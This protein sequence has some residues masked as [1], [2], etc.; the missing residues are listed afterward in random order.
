MLQSPPCASEPDNLTTNRQSGH[1]R[2][3]EALRLRIR[4][5]DWAPGSAIP[6][7]RHLAAE[8]KISPATVERA[9]VPLLTDGTL[10][11]DDRRGT[12]VSETVAIGQPATA[13]TS[14]S[15]PHLPASRPAAILPGHHHGPIALLA[16][17]YSPESR[18]AGQND[19]WVHEIVG[20]MEHDLAEHGRHTAFINRVPR[21]TLKPVSLGE[22]LEQALADETLSGLVIVAFDLPAHEIEEAYTIV[23]RRHI[24]MVSI[25]S[26]PLSLSVPHVLLDNYRAGFQ[27]AQYMLDRGF[28][29]VTAFIP[30]HATWAEE[31]LE[32]IRAAMSRAQLP[33]D[34]VEILRGQDLEWEYN[35][36]PMERAAQ[37][38][39][40]SLENGWKPESPVICA[41]DMA[42][43]VLMDALTERGYAVG[44]QIPVLGFDDHELSR[45]AGLT[46]LRPPL[47]AM[48]A[49][50]ARLLLAGPEAQS[51]GS[52][53]RLCPKL[54]PRRST[55][56]IAHSP[57]VLSRSQFANSGNPTAFALPQEL[58][59]NERIP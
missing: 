45:D 5:G 57:H 40:L 49:E 43:I 35:N 18:N 33:P 38:V 41:T 25:V 55:A 32:G 56:G 54:I 9:I 37:A 6:S 59:V 7:R 46:T 48:G 47:R 27:A 30:E 20:T 51:T 28:H 50:A 58:P 34:S 26:E 15:T 39:N 1:S 24:P 16:A 17:L 3:T 14:W 31:R 19:Y 22:S 44:S 10:R 29:S 8:Y 12:F 36:D 11:A 21:P 2:I 13:P 52:Q 4:N 23:S 42:A 53:V